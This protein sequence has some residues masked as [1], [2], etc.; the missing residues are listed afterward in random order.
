M[1]KLVYL[2]VVAFAASM[3]ACGGS[4]KADANAEVADTEV[5]AAVVETVDTT[6][7][8][9]DTCKCD[10]C[11]CDTVCVNAAAVVEETTNK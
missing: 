7:C 1:K 10:T 11:K 2:A 9:C 5:T 3:V 6:G 4:E 8:K